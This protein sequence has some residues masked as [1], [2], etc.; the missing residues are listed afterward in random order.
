MFTYFRIRTHAVKFCEGVVLV[1]SYHTPDSEIKGDDQSLDSVPE[2]G[3]LKREDL[4]ED[5]KQ[6]FK[7]MLAFLGSQSITR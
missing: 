4:E 5:G 1:L 6:V 2:S 7:R 3:F